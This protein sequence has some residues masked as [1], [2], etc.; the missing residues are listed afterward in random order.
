MT[1]LRADAAALELVTSGSDIA[2][3][4][5]DT[6]VVL[7]EL[8]TE[9]EHRVLVVGFAVHQGR[10]I[11][12]AL[13]DRMRQRADLAVRLCL[14]VRRSPGDTTRADM[15]LR[16]FVERF[17]RQEWPGPRLPDLFYDPRSLTGGETARASLHAKCAVVDGTKA[18]S[19]SANFTEAAQ[20]RNIEVGKVVNRPETA[21]AVERHFQ[22]LIEYA[23]VGT[24]QRREGPVFHDTIYKRQRRLGARAELGD[25]LVVHLAEPR[26]VAHSR[27]R[28]D[29]IGLPRQPLPRPPA[30]LL[31][32]A[33]KVTG[34]PCPIVEDHVRL[35]DSQAAMA[36]CRDHSPTVDRQVFAQPAGRDTRR[37][38]LSWAESGPTRVASRRTGVRYIA[39]IPAASAK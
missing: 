6:G 7:R 11:F 22:A 35:K 17:V 10:E 18:L 5:R 15:L 31:G 28:G 9:A 37:N 16:R 14:D 23:H 21:V 33:F 24:P 39:V 2:G 13:A 34:L 20:V 19:G 3:A 36:Q 12:A 32:A 29:V 8:F 25:H 26:R 30:L 4:T 38:R 27:D 1:W